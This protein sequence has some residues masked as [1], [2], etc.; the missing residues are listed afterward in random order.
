[1]VYKTTSG[2]TQWHPLQNTAQHY[3]YYHPPV[4]QTNH[5]APSN[6][7]LHPVAPE[8]LKNRFRIANF[9]TPILSPPTLTAD[10]PN[11]VYLSKKSNPFSQLTPP[12]FGLAYNAMPTPQN[13]T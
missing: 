5:P 1:M 3:T 8:L 11:P 2:R 6:I 9:S 13:S 7:T 4:N 10:L 12:N